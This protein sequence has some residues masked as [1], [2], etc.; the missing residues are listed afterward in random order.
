MLAK[1]LGTI[2]IILGLLWLIRPQILQNR[3]KRKMDRR[4]RWTVYF[5]LLAFGILMAGSVIK[6]PGFL[7]KIVGIIGIIIAIK[8]IL[9]M[10]SKASGK[11]LEWC[12]GQPIII[13]RAVALVFLVVGIMMVMA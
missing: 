13:F 8:G 3:L 12:A 11:M 9:L 4:F 5:A 10:T 6:L 2:W 7:A 1:I